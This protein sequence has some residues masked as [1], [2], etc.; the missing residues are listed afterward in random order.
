[1]PGGTRSTKTGASGEKRRGLWRPILLL[2]VIVAVFVLSYVFHVGERLVALRG[3]IHSLGAL[4]PV[5]FALIYAVAT[6]LALPGS[7][8]T[9]IGGALFGSVLGVITVIIA[10]T[11]GAGLS[12]LI[13]RYFARD[14]VG[15]WLSDKEK[16][17]KL[18]EMTEEHGA[19][20]VAL[21]RLVPI[22]P[23]NLLNY[24]FGLTRVRFWTYVFWSF[25]CM[26]PGTILYVVGADALFSG[27]A[28]GRIPWT[29][30]TILVAMIVIV[31]LIVRRARR[32]LHDRGAGT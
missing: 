21:T 25:L 32:H 18:D 3:W 22:F 13:A 4:G 28:E 11:L 10:A 29:L 1:M 7:A 30:L 2:G 16:F 26:L 6:V 31:T 9:I 8:M 19:I 12:F 20:I 17:R 24:G 15:R 5:V 14:A 27:I 23:F